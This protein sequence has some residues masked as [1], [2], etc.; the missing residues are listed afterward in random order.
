MTQWLRRLLVILSGGPLPPGGGSATRTWIRALTILGM[1]LG[2]VVM[3]Y[4]VVR[5]LQHGAA[6]SLLISLAV[7]TAGPGEDLLKASVRRLGGSDDVVAI[8]VLFVD[9]LTS[10]IFLV[11]LILAIALVQ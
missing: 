7:I 8:R 4:G 1:A 3:V 2:V 6:P 10:A 11:F 5:F 9:R